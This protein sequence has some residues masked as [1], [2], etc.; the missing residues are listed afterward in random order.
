MSYF[1]ILWFK[2]VALECTWVQILTWPL[3][4]YVT[5]DTLS[6]MPSALHSTN[7]TGLGRAEMWLGAMLSRVADSI[8]S[9]SGFPSGCF[10]SLN[11]SF[12]PGISASYS[13]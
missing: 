11:G 13:Y 8:S 1:M 3:P 5:L 7:P 10:L 4:S 6:L 9:A 2:A 12:G